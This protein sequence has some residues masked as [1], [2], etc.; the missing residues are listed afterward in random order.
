[1]ASLHNKTVLITGASSG[2]GK[3]CAE[4]FA[5]LG[6]RLILTARRESLLHQVTKKLQAEHKVEILPVILDVTNAVAVQQFFQS[7]PDAWQSID[8]LVNNAGLACGAEKIYENHEADWDIV[9]DTNIKG[10]LYVTK[11]TLL[12]MLKQNSGHVI[13][14]GSVA[15][16]EVY[17]GGAVYCASKFAVRAISDGIKMDVHGTPI[18]VSEIDPGIVKTDFSKI[19]FKGDEKRADA[20]YAGINYLTA[21]DIADTVIY[22]ATRP[23]HV[24]I[25]NIKIMPTDQTAPHMVKRHE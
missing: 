3:A 10:L 15:G 19:R 8:I 23:P 5:A 2:I 16:F 9:I 11:Q 1:M 7:L 17:P 18:R 24:D 6:T 21:E 12:L 25:R 20:V 14:I 13:N 22:C 4:Q